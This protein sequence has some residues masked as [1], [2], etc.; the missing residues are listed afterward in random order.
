MP[1]IIFKQI[2]LEFEVEMFLAFLDRDW[3]YKITEKYPNFLEIRNIKEEKEREKAVETELIRIKEE[4]GNKLDSN[5]ELIKEGWE[6]VQEETFKILSD[7]IQEDWPDKEITAHVSLNPICPRH[8]DL[9]SFSVPHD[10]KYPNLVITHEISHFLYFKKFKNDFP[11]IDRG[12]YESPHKE[13]LLSE[14][15]T[16]I[17]LNDPRILK[18]IGPG[19]GF[20]EKHKELKVGNKPLTESIQELYTEFVINKNNFSEFIKKSLDVVTLLK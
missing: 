9:W 12:K 15:I 3:S 14:I 6:K 13:W 4:L 19:A 16:P 11:D 17:I 8:L 7:I 18:I 1:K 2:P 5:L 20:Y 10:R